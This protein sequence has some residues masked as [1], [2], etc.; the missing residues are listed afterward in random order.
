M[1]RY[2][3]PVIFLLSLVF[4]GCKKMLEEKPR[5]LVR[6]GGYFTNAANFESAVIGIYSSFPGMFGGNQLMMSEMFSDIYAT[7]S[8]AF[9]QALPTYQN[10]MSEAFYNVRQAWTTCYTII[11]DANFVL[12]YL[13]TT[14]LLTDVKKAQLTA[15]C[16]FL[17]AYAYFRLVQF[18]GDVP[19]R[20][21]VPGSYDETQIPRTPQQEVYNFILEDLKYAENNLPEDAAQKGRVY[22][23]AAT[24]LLAKV[25]LTMAGHPLNQTA[26]YQDALAKSLQVINSPKFVLV[27]DY[28]RVFRNATYTTESIWEQTYAPGTGNGIHTLSLTQKGFVPILLPASWFVN[29]FGTGDRRGSFGIIKDFNDRVNNVT[30]PVFFSKFVDTAYINQDR[31]SGNSGTAY[32]I[33]FLRLGEMY[34]I[35]AEAENEINGPNNAYTYVNKIRWRAREDKTNPALVPDFAGLNKA[36]LRDSILLERKKELFQEGST[37]FDLKRTKTLSRIQVIRGTGLSVPIGAYNDTWYIPDIELS[38]NKVPQ[39]PKYQ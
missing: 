37:W 9:E 3:L 38:I 16:R 25:Y 10:N 4:A 39:N 27:E 20:K 5:N 34:L 24:A 18:Y 26:H 7:P 28:A 33:P 11:K 8:S 12:T 35:A 36:Q 32:T 22:K 13:P 21:E 30:L 15:E 23:M 29:S 31:N 1:K 17:R 19:L 6:P 14:T 2:C